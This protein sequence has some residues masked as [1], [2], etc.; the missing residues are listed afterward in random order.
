VAKRV[1]LAHTRERLAAEPQA[2]GVREL[3]TARRTKRRWGCVSARQG[4]SKGAWAET[5]D[6]TPA[7]GQP[8]SAF[9]LLIILV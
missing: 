7:P 3:R 1:L 8:C 6:P 4:G 9:A 2:V 5:R